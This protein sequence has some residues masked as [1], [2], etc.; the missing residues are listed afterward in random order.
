ML[1]EVLHVA[2]R[3]N[4]ATGPFAPPDLN[5]F[6]SVCKVTEFV[7]A[8]TFIPSLAFLAEPLLAPERVLDHVAAL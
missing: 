4:F 6:D 8:G 2:Y 7:E 1:A 5:V 3:V